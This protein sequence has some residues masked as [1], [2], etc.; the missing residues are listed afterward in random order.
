MKHNL[1]LVRHGESLGNR[2]PSLCKNDDLNFLTKRGVIQSELAGITLHDLN[3][4]IKY[5]VCSPYLRARQTA[6]TL[7]QS[8]NDNYNIE[9]I[10]DL[11]E[12]LSVEGVYKESNEDVKT[13]VGK[14]IDSN[15]NIKLQKGNVLCVSHYYT[16]LAFFNNYKIKFK[17]NPM[18]LNA[19]PTIIY[20]DG[21]IWALPGNEKITE[22]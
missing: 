5:V 9:I 15:L 8:M 13:R 4:N 6:I 3:I 1:I 22:T 16:M 21:N 17:W 18:G 7:C 14:V 2:T 20:P 19:V 12:R 11:R 10:D